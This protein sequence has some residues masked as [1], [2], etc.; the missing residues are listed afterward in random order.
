MNAPGTH[1][2]KTNEKLTKLFSEGVWLSTNASSSA[3][4]GQ[5]LDKSSVFDERQTTMRQTVCWLCC[6][7]TEMWLRHSEQTRQREIC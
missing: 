1:P 3:S 4:H 2:T 5:M 6:R 7:S